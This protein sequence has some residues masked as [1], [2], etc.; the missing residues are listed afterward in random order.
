MLRRPIESALRAVVGMCDR[1]G[2][3]AAGPLGGVQCAGDE[4]GAH[5]VGE[6][7]AGQAPRGEVDHGGQIQELPAF[8]REIRDVTDV[9]AVQDQGS[10]PV[11][12]AKYF[13]AR[14]RISRSSSSSRIR[15]RAVAS[16]ASNGDCGADVGSFLLPGWPRGHQAD[17]PAGSAG[18][19]EEENA[20]LR[21]KIREIEEEREI[22]RKAA[23]CFAGETRW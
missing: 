13:A 17:A 23:K 6:C 16:S 8:Q 10:G 5:V 19:L 15:L 14:R 11:S 12:P 1:S 2:E 7:P 22:L 3:A 9:F 18:P 4:F 21:K 20:A